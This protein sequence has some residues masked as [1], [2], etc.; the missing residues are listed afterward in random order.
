[1]LR[2]AGAHHRPARDR[3]DLVRSVGHRTA[4]SRRLAVLLVGLAALLFA[5]GVAFG[6]R[7]V[8]RR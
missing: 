2:P 8:R 7:R 1:V 5:V 3:D 4:V 6:V